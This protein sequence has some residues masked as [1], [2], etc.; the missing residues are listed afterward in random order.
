MGADPLSASLNRNV[1]ALSARDNPLS[2]AKG[3]LVYL[4]RHDNA[5][6]KEEKNHEKE[7]G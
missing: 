1:T 2:F 5:K 3:P 4:N 7:T 6:S